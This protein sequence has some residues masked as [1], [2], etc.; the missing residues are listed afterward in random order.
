MYVSI[1]YSICRTRFP[2]GARHALTSTV[3][4]LR[5]LSTA[6][7]GAQAVPVAHVDTLQSHHAKFEIQLPAAHALG[8]V[9][10]ICY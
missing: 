5:T 6:P 7:V 10:S 8:T 1:N 9:L 4:T 3:Q 2:P